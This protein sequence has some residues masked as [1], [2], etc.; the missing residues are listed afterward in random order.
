[1]DGRPNINLWGNIL[2]CIE[3]G[4]NIYAI[5][6]D[7]NKGLQM[8]YDKAEHNLSENVL[9]LGERSGEN[10]CF[11]DGLAADLAVKELKE[12]NLITDVNFSEKHDI[13]MDNAKKEVQEYMIEESMNQA[14][15]L[16]QEDSG[17]EELG[18]LDYEL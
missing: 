14:Q 7:K 18:E 4:L 3:V 12:Q 15:D 1:M 5:I 16:A 10:I 11:T 13:E 2:T 6:G 17:F 8:E 9:N